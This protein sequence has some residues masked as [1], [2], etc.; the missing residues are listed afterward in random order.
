M[1]RLR[2]DVSRLLERR[3]AQHGH[4]VAALDESEMNR[5]SVAN[6]D[7]GRRIAPVLP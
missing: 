4:S 3:H 1:R 5:V 2:A 7:D 6:S